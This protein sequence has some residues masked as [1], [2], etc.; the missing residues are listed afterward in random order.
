[1]RQYIPI[2]SDF[3]NI[4]EQRIEEIQTKLNNSPRKRFD[5]ESPIFVMEKLLFNP[6]VAFV[7]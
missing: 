5:F 7:A 3:L 1:M 2:S 4:S 6:E